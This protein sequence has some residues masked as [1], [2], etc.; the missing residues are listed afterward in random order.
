[1]SQEGGAGMLLHTPQH[2]GQPLMWFKPPGLIFT[3]HL[4]AMGRRGYLLRDWASRPRQTEFIS[5]S[6]H[7]PNKRR[8]GQL[9]SLSCSVAGLSPLYLPPAPWVSH[10]PAQ[11]SGA[12]PQRQSQGPGLGQVAPTAPL[13]MLW[14]QLPWEARGWRGWFLVSD[15]VIW[16]HTPVGVTVKD[17]RLTLE[18]VERSKPLFAPGGKQKRHSHSGQEPG[19]SS[20]KLNKGPVGTWKNAQHDQSSEKRQSKPQR[21]FFS[22]KKTKSPYNCHNGYHQKVYQ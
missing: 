9:L 7:P 21:F 8:V 13:S 2:L 6:Q 18:G 14:G 5:K 17:R 4:V 1:M 3:F 10:P 19:C 12:A 20:K 11:A 16:H 22:H 15:A